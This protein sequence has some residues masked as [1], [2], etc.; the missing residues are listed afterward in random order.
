MTEAEGDGGEEAGN[1]YV[2]LSVS[3]VSTFLSVVHEEGLLIFSY[4][5]NDFF[6]HK[7][8]ISMKLI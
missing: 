4:L 8:F 5:S 7:P 2:M 1:N 3:L 6:I